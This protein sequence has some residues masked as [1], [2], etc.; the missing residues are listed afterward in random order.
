MICMNLSGS[1]ELFLDEKK[2]FTK[3]PKG[4]DIIFLPDTTAHAGKGKENKAPNTS[5]MTENYHFE[6]YAWYSKEVEIGS[7]QMEKSITLF[8]ERT[9]VSTVFI[10]GVELDTQNSLCGF[11][12]HDL[13]GKLTAGVHILTVRVDNTTV[14]DTYLELAEKREANQSFV[15]GW[16]K[17]R[18]IV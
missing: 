6:G 1:W 13:S 7:E 18:V 17:Q 3:P 8:L 9:R 4:N 11:H 12:K 16:L 10:D 15:Y 14:T 5:Y 2:E